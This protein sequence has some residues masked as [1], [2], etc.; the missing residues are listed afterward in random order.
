M[1]RRKYR[2][3]RL[4]QSQGAA[5]CTC[6]S[7]GLCAS[8][9]LINGLHFPGLSHRHTVATIGRERYGTDKSRAPI[10][11]KAVTHIRTYSSEGCD[12]AVQPKLS[13]RMT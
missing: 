9:D 7:V 4:T 1:I 13:W 11:S 12:P 6:G 2:R 3:L 10:P 8:I 5:T